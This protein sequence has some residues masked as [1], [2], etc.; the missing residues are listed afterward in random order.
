MKNGPEQVRTVLP[1]TG[2]NGA[3]H[4]TNG[5]RTN[6]SIPRAGALP[7]LLSPELR[8]D[9]WLKVCALEAQ[10]MGIYKVIGKKRP[11]CDLARIVRELAD[12]L[13]ML[14]QPPAPPARGNTNELVK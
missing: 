7:T 4:G 11:E 14:L 5:R 12:T 8:A 2:L 10:A 1:R 3:N 13:R 9:L 6:G